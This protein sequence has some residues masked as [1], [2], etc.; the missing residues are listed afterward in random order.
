MIARASSSEKNWRMMSEL[1]V[2]VC[3]S[4]SNATFAT[5]GIVAGLDVSLK[6]E[7][8]CNHLLFQMSI[9]CPFPTCHRWPC[10]TTSYATKILLHS[11]DGWCPSSA[12]RKSPLGKYLVLNYLWTREVV[13][14]CSR[15]PCLANKAKL[16]ALRSQKPKPS[17][18]LGRYIFP[19][20]SQDILFLSF[21]WPHQNLGTILVIS[22]HSMLIY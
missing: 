14:I 10:L 21:V 12:E 17:F 3:G 9:D 18:S 7:G 19:Q 1:Q 6:V 5:V 15:H 8:W 22:F 2:R 11:Y 16:K 4:I 20:L 13:H